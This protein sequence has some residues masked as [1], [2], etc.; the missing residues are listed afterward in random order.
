MHIFITEINKQNDPGAQSSIPDVSSNNDFENVSSL[1][2]FH[3]EEDI[4]DCLM[5]SNN[6]LYCYDRETAKTLM[7]L[8]GKLRIVK[9][10]SNNNNDCHRRV[11]DLISNVA[12]DNFIINYRE[13]VYKIMS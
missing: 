5:K 13:L 6:E 7:Y 4:P 10:F 8:I 9:L 3:E 2:K 11:Q 12:D 1:R